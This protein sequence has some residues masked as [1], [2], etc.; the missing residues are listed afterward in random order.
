MQ[1]HFNEKISL[2][3]DDELDKHQALSLLTRLQTDEALKARLHRYQLVSQALKHAEL[4]IPDSDFAKNIQQQIQ[5]EP[6]YFLPA[7]KPVSHW[8]KT[9]LALAAS[10]V[11]AMVWVANKLEKQDTPY[12]Q[13][14][15]AVILPSQ[16]QLQ[17]DPA[18]DRFNEYLQAHDNSVYVNHVGRAQPYA[19]VAGFQQE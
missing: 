18:N 8:R 15:I 5:R 11:L 10:F 13:P 14:Q 2:L 7:R 6:V 9:S 1:E 16:Q 4:H 3:L 19:R 17:R 12:G